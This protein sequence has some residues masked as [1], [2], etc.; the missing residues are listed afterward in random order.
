M[1]LGKV[2]N[3]FSASEL[4]GDTRIGK[5]KIPTQHDLLNI[6]YIKYDKWILNKYEEFNTIFGVQ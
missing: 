3:H 1:A 4:P 2:F 6:E 5:K